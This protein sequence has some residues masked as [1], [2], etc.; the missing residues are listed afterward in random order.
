[1]STVTLEAVE[2]MLAKQYRDFQRTIRYVVVVIVVM[3]A[4]LATGTVLLYQNA[5]QPARIFKQVDKE[6]ARQTAAE[7]AKSV[8]GHAA[9]CS[10]LRDN[11]LK[12]AHQVQVYFGCPLSS[13]H[14]T[15]TTRKTNSSGRTTT[16]TVVV[17]PGTTVIEKEGKGGS[18]PKQSHPTT[19]PATSPTPKPSPTCSGVS[20]LGRC[21]V[22]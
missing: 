2:G 15:T 17:R 4:A 11:N 20:L 8:K 14:T 16:T 19:P 5:T 13:K 21:L 1:V 9:I 18:H 12:A 22:Q 3:L 7:L 10:L 6:F